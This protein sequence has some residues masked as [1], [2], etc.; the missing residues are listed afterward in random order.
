MGKYDLDNREY[1]NYLVS[2][3]KEKELRQRKDARRSAN[4]GYEGWHFGIDQKPVYTKNK[5]EF[6]RELDKRGLIMH[7][8][9]KGKSIID[10]KK[11]S[12]E[13]SN[14]ERNRR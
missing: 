12:R 13:M 10:Q 11:H 14:Y 5:E 6:R 7:D 1:D 9:V 3:K 8:D 4:K 2:Q